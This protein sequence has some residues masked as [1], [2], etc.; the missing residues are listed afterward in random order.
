MPALANS[1]T[2]SEIDAIAKY[3]VKTLVVP[4]AITRSA[5]APDNP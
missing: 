1:L 4:A 3:V 2:V 5:A